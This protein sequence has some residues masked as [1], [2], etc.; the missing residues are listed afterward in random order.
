MV[1]HPLSIGCPKQSKHSCFM[2]IKSSLSF[3]V[4]SWNVGQSSRACFLVHPNTG[5]STFFF[6]G[7]PVAEDIWP[8]VPPSG[9]EVGGASSASAAALAALLAPLFL[10]LYFWALVVILVG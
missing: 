10:F 8:P 9:P 1:S 5:H 6:L 7:N 2:W 4:M 3:G